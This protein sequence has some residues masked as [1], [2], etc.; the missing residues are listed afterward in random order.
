MGAAARA[1]AQ[2]ALRVAG[3]RRAARGDLRAGR[4]SRERE[5][6]RV[7]TLQAL[8]RNPWARGLF[9]LASLVAAMLALWWRGPGVGHRLRRVRLRQLALGRRR[10]RPQPALG[11]RP[12]ALL[13]PHDPPGA[14]AAAADGSRRCSR[15]SASVS[16]ATPCSRPAPA[17]WRASPCCGGICPGRPGT[18]A[19]LL[20]T[21]FS[22]RLFDL[23]PIALL[24]A[25]VV[26]TAKLPHWAVTGV[27]IL[28]LVGLALLAVAML[29]ARRAHGAAP[30][31]PRTASRLLAMAR[32][33]LAVLRTPG[34]RRSPRS[35]C[36]PSAGRS[37]C[38]RSGR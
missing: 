9:V 21:V 26:A 19:T 24:V 36:R 8:A 28:G 27:V 32:Q 10:R 20:G 6:G 31:G 35:C 4:R 2:R 16:S 17:S 23:F 12:R 30:H 38:S 18:S 14:R 33:G 1:L 7:T 29:G 37:S 34:G 22:H 25:Y 5:G 11:A 3:H 15:R 13:E